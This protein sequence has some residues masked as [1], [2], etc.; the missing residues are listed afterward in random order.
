MSITKVSNTVNRSTSIFYLL[1]QINFQ[2]GWRYYIEELNIKVG[3]INFFFCQELK[4]SNWLPAQV[5]EKDILHLILLNL[6]NSG[7][8]G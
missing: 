1:T 3:R 8:S 2:T 7:I 5:N 4:D 6:R